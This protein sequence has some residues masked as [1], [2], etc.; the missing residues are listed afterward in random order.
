MGCI[1]CNITSCEEFVQGPEPAIKNPFFLSEK[2]KFLEEL[3][4]DIAS[5]HPEMVEKINEYAVKL[6]KNVTAG[7]ELMGS[8]CWWHRLNQWAR[9]VRIR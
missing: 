1:L 8:E 9:S 6:S 2:E 4:Y 5:K 3:A 7:V